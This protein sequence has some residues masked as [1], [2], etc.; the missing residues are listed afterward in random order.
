MK[1]AKIALVGMTGCG[2]STTGVLLAQQMGYAFYDVDRIIEERECSSVGDIFANFGE[3]VFRQHETAALSYLL[4]LGHPAVLACGGGIVLSEQNRQMLA[5]HATT[6]L[7][8]RPA[9]LVLAN[10]TVLARPPISGSSE[11]YHNLFAIRQ[12]LYSQMAQFTVDCT[13]VEVASLK[14][15]E[16]LSV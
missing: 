8:T 12:P 7:L 6:I 9:E 4:E 14:I 15:I 16:F 10:P 13:D 3:E 11:N 2:K 5:D 1:K